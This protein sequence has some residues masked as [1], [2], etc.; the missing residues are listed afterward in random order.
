MK[1]QKCKA[2]AM[3]LGPNVG[4]RFPRGYGSGEKVST[5]RDGS[6]EGKSGPK[7]KGEK[8]AEA[9]EALDKWQPLWSGLVIFFGTNV[10]NSHKK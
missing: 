4:L 5:G 1:L 3:L 10:T 6:R 8:T 7:K 2:Q 9:S